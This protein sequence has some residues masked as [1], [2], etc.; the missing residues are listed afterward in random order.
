MPD[1]KR[2]LRLLKT[3]SALKGARFHT[4]AQLAARFGISERT[5][6]RDLS[7]LGRDW[8]LE[9]NPDGSGYRL[10]P[11]AELPPL[12]LT[13]E[14]T[15]LL[16]ALLDQSVVTR[17]GELRR[18]ARTL[19]TKL[20]A[21]VASFDETPAGLK[22]A[23]PDR[24]GPQAERA[25]VGLRHA[26]ENHRAVEIVYE[27]LSG[28]E[29]RPRPRRLDPWQLFHRGDAWYVVGF[30]RVHQ[31]PRVFRLDRISKVTELAE[32]ARRPDEVAAGAEG[33]GA[34]EPF[35]LDAF[36]ADSW[37]VFTGRA[38]HEVVVE[39]AAAVA[40]LVAN[41]RHHPGER[42]KKLPNGAIE[43]RVTLTSLEEIARWLL[44]FGG[45][46]K[47]IDPPELRR[48]VVALARAALEANVPDAPHPRRRLTDFPRPRT[49]R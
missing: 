16:R 31:E 29:Q 2:T 49:T 34:R 37:S 11:S 38:R 43:Y 4:V 39:F 1:L 36:L 17:D 44:G 40:P 35:D 28:R 32:P 15:A 33:S 18:V 45:A 20:A 21:A 46:A 24:S 6:F 3:L 30:C 41:A 13:V 48:R 19:A 42:Q 12:A 14:E 7:D 47:V 26:I 9:S 22:L 27:S 10:P 25:R 23:T 8:P 5:V